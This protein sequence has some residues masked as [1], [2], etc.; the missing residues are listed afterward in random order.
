[1]TG[2][3]INKENFILDNSSSLVSLDALYSFAMYSNIRDDISG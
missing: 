2:V 3:A 1:M